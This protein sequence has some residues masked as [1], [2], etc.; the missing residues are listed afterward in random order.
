MGLAPNISLRSFILG[1][2]RVEVLLEPLNRLTCGCKSHSGL[3]LEQS[4]LCGHLRLLV[5]Q[6]KKPRSIPATAS[7]GERDLREAGVGLAAPR[8]SVGKHGDLV[9]M[10]IPFATENSAGPN[11]G[12]PT[13]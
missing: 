2:K 10:T 4:S 3:T 12:T 7:N 6:P 5:S 1:I 11:L 13:G 9:H 8:K